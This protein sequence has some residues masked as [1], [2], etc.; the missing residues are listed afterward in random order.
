MVKIKDN[1]I[2]RLSKRRIRDYR[3]GI[4]V[5]GKKSKIL[6]DKYRPTPSNQAFI[7]K[8]LFSY[9]TELSIYTLEHLTEC[10]DEVIHYT[11]N[12]YN[13]R[14]KGKRLDIRK[15]DELF[16]KIRKEFLLTDFKDATVDQRISQADRRLK[17]NLLRELET[18][19]QAYATGL[20]DYETLINTITGKDYQNGGTA[21]RWNSRLVLSEMYRAYQ[22][23]GKVVLAE[24]GVSEVK[25]ENSPRHKPNDS[26]I[27][28]YAEK[29]YKPDK[30]PE[31]P[32]PCNDSYFIPIY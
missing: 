8:W 3:N 4:E 21:Y 13:K 32:Y 24:L 5:Y 16:M 11:I 1:P 29:T 22:F 30:L 23:T 14:H 12:F 2:Y 28:E 18:L 31:Y 19:T 6:L 10:V 7:Q 15:K 26:I 20:P 17:V 9:A 25:W 27:D